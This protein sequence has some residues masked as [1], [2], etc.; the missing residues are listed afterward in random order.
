MAMAIPFV[1]K[2][3]AVT[4]FIHINSLPPNRP[5]EIAALVPPRFASAHAAQIAISCLSLPGCL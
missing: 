4:A 1:A 2:F 3:S 5:M